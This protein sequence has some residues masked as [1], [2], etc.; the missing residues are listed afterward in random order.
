MS[1]CP[2]GDLAAHRFLQIIASANTARNG[3]T[4][5]HAGFAEWKSFVMQL[6]ID[7]KRRSLLVRGG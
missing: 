4:L 2:R 5:I 7:D 6:V 1:K 3:L